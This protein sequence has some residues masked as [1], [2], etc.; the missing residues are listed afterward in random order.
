VQSVNTAGKSFRSGLHV[1]LRGGGLRPVVVV[2]LLAV[3]LI[4]F[5]D[6]NL[7]LRDAGAAPL[8]SPA[9]ASGVGV[10]GT[11]NAAVASTIGGHG[12]VVIKYVS[13]GTP[14]YETFNY[15]G[16]NQTWTV[17][18]GVTSAT[19]FLLG[20]GGGGSDSDYNTTYSGGNGGGGG[21]AT[22]DY[23]VSA[24]QSFTIIVGGAGGGLDGVNLSGNNW[25]TPATYGGGGQGG[26]IVNVAGGYASGGGRSAIRVG[27]ATT[28]LATAGGGGGAGATNNSIST[29]ANGAPG[30][31]TSGASVGS[32]YGGQG[33]T[34]SAGG[35]GGTSGWGVSYGGTAGSQFAGGVSRDEGGGGGGGWYGGGGG[36]DTAVSPTQGGFGGGGGSSYVALLTNGS[37]T[38]GSGTSPGAT[39]P[40]TP[41]TSGLSCSTNTASLNV[42][43]TSDGGTPL[44]NYEYH[45]ATTNKPASQPT[46]WTAFDP[47][48][49][50]S[51]LTWDL[52][53]LGYTSGT[54]RFY[55][56]AVN[57]L[58]VSTGSWLS[59]SDSSCGITITASAPGAPTSLTA[60]PGSGSA[61]ISFIA[62]A[63]NGGAISNY[64]YSL[65]GVTYTAL[66][67]ADATSPITIPGLTG[68]TA[69][70]VYLKARNSAGLSSASAAVSVTPLAAAPTLSSVSTTSGTSAGGTSITITGSNFLAGATVTVGGAACTSV[71]VVSATSIT[72]TTPAGTAGAQDVVV[73]N[74]DTQSATLSSG[75]TYIQAPATPATPVVDTASDSG[76]S[77][78][79]NITSDNTPTI[80]VGSATNGNTVTVTATKAGSANVTCTFTAT[81]QTSCDLGTLADGTWSITS[82]QT[83]GGVSSA[84]STALTMTVD[85]TRPTV[86]SFFSTTAN[87]TYVVGTTIN[88]TATLSETVENGASLTVT[89][90]TGDTVVL[91]KATG[92]TLTGTYTVGAGDSS[93]DLTVSSYVLTSAPTDAAGNVTTSTTVPTGANNIAGAQAIVIDTGGPTVVSSSMN[94]AGTQMSVTMSETLNT[95]TA[96]TSD[97]AVTVGGTS[98]TVSSV[99]I[100]GSTVVLTISP[101]AQSGSTVN[102]S[103]TAPVTNVATSNAALQDTVGNDAV[104]FA[105]SATVPAVGATVSSPQTGTTTTSTSTT[106]ST[107]T[108]TTIAV[109]ATF[110]TTPVRSITTAPQ[111]QDVVVPVVSPVEPESISTQTNT[112][113]PNP[114]LPVTT[115]EMVR[116]TQGIGSVAGMAPGGWVKVEPVGTNS[117][118]LTT[119]DGLR[120]EIAAL[121][122]DKKKV[123]LNSR[124]MVIVEHDDFITVGGGGL[125]PASDASTW[126]FSTPKALGSFTVD[127][128][129]NFAQQ[130]QIGPEVPVGDHT[131]QINGL[132]PDGTLRSVEVGVEVIER[133][134]QITAYNPRSEPRNV[135]GLTAEALVL[136]TVL[137][138]AAAARKEERESG[139]VAEV[140]VSFRSSHTDDRTDA[141]RPLA[142]PALDRMSYELPTR[143]VKRSPLIARIFADGA[144]I[145]ALLGVWWLI[146]PVLGATIGVLAAIDTSYLVVMPSLSL[147]VAIIVLGIAD[148]FAGFI[149]MSLFAAVVAANGGFT[150]SD[151]VRGMLG[152]WVLAFAVPLAASAVRPF[153]RLVKEKPGVWERTTD[154]VLIALFG[155]WAA[156][157]MFSALPGLTGI[158]TEGADEIDLV[159]LAALIALIVRFGFENLARIFAPKRLMAIEN[160][161]LPEV[162]LAQKVFSLLVRTVVFVFVA[163][164][165]IGNNWALWVGGA[166]YL[167]PKLVTLFDDAFPDFSPIHRFMPRGIFKTV[168]MLLVAQWWGG[169]VAD[170]VANPDNMV[171]YGFVL[172]GIPGLVLGAIGWFGRSSKPWPST[173]LT[174]VLGVAL[175]V[176]G[177]T[178]VLG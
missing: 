95:T 70:T 1:W 105:S 13:S 78:S 124:G 32:V 74:T 83:N 139:D 129:G 36:G 57:G 59:N 30:G 89:L 110:P 106:T 9:C 101:A 15:T 150:S 97:Y 153:R 144:Y 152:L 87:G 33:G 84:S 126:L 148:A 25:Q 85:T 156:G 135:V 66:S 5:P 149:A 50:T 35:A 69:Y 102:V 90:N 155:A 67:P 154:A 94:S 128:S 79:D 17:P 82:V 120:I 16:A 4:T 61:S 93:N 58:G 20:A 114:L 146:L 52:R 134:S 122:N 2:A 40:S 27:G 136:L 54:F 47:A 118:V 168:V 119:S 26:S 116:I 171:Q 44:V 72:C 55:V 28:D 141:I 178:L 164:I 34:Q 38:A 24:G 62:G 63:T 111:N 103:Y 12:C 43:L 167:V 161:S 145:R 177:L 51:P 100:S 7:S 42:T 130:Y 10:G 92:T 104:S 121:T 88:I 29:F 143:A 160:Q 133:P 172:L 159:R 157:A 18:S 137:G 115:Q 39:F 112:L 8:S 76:S 173:V 22:G 175:L 132:A 6:R 77:N 123:R 117:V 147:M 125:M 23:V 127:G 165:F 60:T 81:A 170:N 140:S 163:L 91:T 107:T 11:K 56:R 21:F 14:Q 73:T 45:I 68:G 37:T 80:S 31:G 151:S 46:T 176:F 53:A 96:A 64:E 65:D 113:L 131:A 19:F 48:Q 162:P 108:T 98:L 109:I 3:L 71:T 138:G 158:K 142:L 75:F 166:M 169:V 86:T 49:T 174:K 99:T 41:S